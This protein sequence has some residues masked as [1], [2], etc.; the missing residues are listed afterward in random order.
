M[1][2]VNKWKEGHGEAGRSAPGSW[3]YEP[4][5]APAKKR[6]RRPKGFRLDPKL[7]KGKK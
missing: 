5:P 2:R 3:D 4:E 6:K 7:K 1:S